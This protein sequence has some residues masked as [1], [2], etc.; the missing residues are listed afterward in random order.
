MVV[1][2]A[3]VVSLVLA[4]S[5]LFVADT[6]RTFQIYDGYVLNDP[7][8]VIHRDDI[9]GFEN[10]RLR[11][12]RSNGCKAFSYSPIGNCTLTETY[13]QFAARPGGRVGV[14]GSEKQ[15]RLQ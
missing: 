9:K 15:P 5:G 10:C 1:T 12:E 4:F 11:C 14:R 7:G 13:D 8:E 6:S 2:V 3:L